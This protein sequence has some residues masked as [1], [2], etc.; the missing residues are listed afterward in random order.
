MNVLQILDGPEV[1]ERKHAHRQLF[2]SL[3]FIA[4]A[5]ARQRM[6]ARIEQHITLSRE[7]S[8]PARRLCSEELAAFTADALLEAKISI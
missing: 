8:K 4:D 2:R 7:E 5:L 6:E 3:A 1:M